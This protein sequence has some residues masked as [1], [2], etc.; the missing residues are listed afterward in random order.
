MFSQVSSSRGGHAELS[1]YECKIGTNV[2]VRMYRELESETKSVCARYSVS[3]GKPEGF[4]WRKYAREYF[5]P[6]VLNGRG[7]W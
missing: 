3:T 1:T 2:L 5:E 6:I 7:G 4:W